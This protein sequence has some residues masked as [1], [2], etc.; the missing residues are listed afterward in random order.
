MR[1]YTRV[2]F[3]LKGKL[4]LLKLKLI[5]LKSL[6]N[7]LFVLFLVN[8]KIK[9]SSLILLSRETPLEVKLTD[10]QTHSNLRNPKMSMDDKQLCGVVPLCS[11]KAPIS[12]YCTKKK[13]S[14][15][16]NQIKLSV[17]ARFELS[18]VSLL[19]AY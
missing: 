18:I 4:Y 16:S 3:L 1:V 8:N 6:I 13:Y 9:S 19:L 11:R 5:C 14:E 2:I 10:L 12:L 17:L 15:A 7:E